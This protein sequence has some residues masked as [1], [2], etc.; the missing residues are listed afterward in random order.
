LAATLASNVVLTLGPHGIA[1]SSRDGLEHFSMPTL[2]REVF[3]VSGAGDTVVA[4]LALALAAGADH[5]AAVALANRAASVV[6]GKFGTATV[7]ADELLQHDEPGR[8]LTRVALRPAAARLRGQGKR[9]V[10]INGSFDVL[11]AG[12]L[13]ILEEARRQGDVLIVGLNSDASVRGYKGPGRPIVPEQQRAQML[14]ALRVVDYVHIFNESDPIA[15]LSEVRPDVH[16]NGAEYGQDCVESGVVKD[17]G[18]R[19]H[20]VGRVAGLST[21]DVVGKLRPTELTSLRA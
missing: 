3:D 13:H 1:F 17:G 9:I 21:T 19:L 11:H 12:H 7:T 8:M 5:E 20:L 18:G 2:A 15:F 14:L 10:T 16:V 6:V 4:T